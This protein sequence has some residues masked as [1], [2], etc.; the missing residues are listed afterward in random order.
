MSDVKNI[1]DLEEGFQSLQEYSDSQFH[2]ISKLNEKVA[3]LES[4]NKSL[5]TM[6]ESNLPSL[7]FNT[8]DLSIGISSEQLICETQLVM[9]KDVAVTRNLTLEEA[10]K[11]QI[12]TDILLKV[13]ASKKPGDEFGVAR[14]TDDELIHLVQVNGK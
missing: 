13:K 12:F 11:F 6:L 9:L 7:G 1:S 8:T 10:K 14:L 2:L 5:K 3:R 4:E